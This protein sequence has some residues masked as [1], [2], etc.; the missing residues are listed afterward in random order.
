ML[1]KDVLVNL[2]ESDLLTRDI[3]TKNLNALGINGNNIG[4]LVSDGV[5]TRECQGVYEFK[6]LDG[7][8]LYGKELFDE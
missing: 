4:K 7:L 3:S 8:V 2:Y 6:D 5:L 1:N